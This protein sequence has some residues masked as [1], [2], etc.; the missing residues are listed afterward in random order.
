MKA[1]VLEQ[2]K[3]LSVRQVSDP[4]PA[5]GEALIQ[6]GLTG[7]CGS[8]VHIFNGDLPIARTPVIPGHEFMGTIA[9]LRDENAAGL[10]VGQRVAVHPLVSCGACVACK[11]GQ[12]HVCAKLVVIGVNR[13]G[14]FAEYVSVPAERLIPLDD[15]LPD[16]VAAL[17]EPFAVGYHACRR[18]GLC[19]GERVL[20]IG[21]G[22]I[23]LFAAIVARRLGAVDIGL[24]E[25][26][27]ARRDFAESHG[28][29]AFDPLRESCLS[30]LA[31]HSGGEGFDIVIETSGVDAGINAAVE[32]AAPRARIVSLGFPAERFA[33]YNVAFGIMK[34]LSFIGSRVYPREEFSET[35]QLLTEAVR[36][37]DIAFDR[38]VMDVRGLDDLERSI[39][40]VAGGKE[41]G[42]ILIRP[43]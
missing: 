37:G 25:P 6:V 26:V 36:A 12:P 15:D 32:A 20:V 16:E 18:A 43:V 34:E 14:A 38:L 2:W 29:A 28:F 42:K 19:P 13:D 40:G 3:S 4:E 27:A 35:V 11:R 41:R 21:G 1:A 31:A 8:D 23:G 7:I 10:A 39:L 22:P 9:G 17:A 24:T 30:D 5:A 33:R